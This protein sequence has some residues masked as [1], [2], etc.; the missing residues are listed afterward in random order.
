MK[1]SLSLCLTSR[2]NADAIVD[3]SFHGPSSRIQ[4]KISE[5]F[6]VNIVK[7]GVIFCMA[8]GISVSPILVIPSQGVERYFVLSSSSSFIGLLSH[9]RRSVFIVEITRLFKNFD[10]YRRCSCLQT[11]VDYYCSFAALRPIAVEGIANRFR[12]TTITLFLRYI[13]QYRVHLRV[14]QLDCSTLGTRRVSR[15]F[16]IQ[17]VFRIDKSQRNFWFQII[18]GIIVDIAFD[19]SI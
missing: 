19:F 11:F 6:C 8:G 4:S 5:I 13:A 15:G 14:R 2:E 7:I 18:F 1:I 3:A 12:I 17:R 16:S 9:Y 10:F